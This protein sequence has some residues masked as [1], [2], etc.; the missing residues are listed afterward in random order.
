MSQ[1]AQPTVSFRPATRDDL[2][3]IVRMLANDQL[4]AI[5]ED[6]RDLPIY[7]AAFAAIA[8]DPNQLLVVGELDGRVVATMQLTFIPGLSHRGSWRAQLEAV[9][10]DESVRGRGIGESMV[11]WACTQARE[12]GCRIVQL[13]TNRVREDAHRFYERF[14]FVASHV[15]MKLTL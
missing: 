5:R 9:R 15:G 8:S 1:N 6:V 10:V 2:P 4:G 7:E 11:E 3:D 13:T 14:G 12:R